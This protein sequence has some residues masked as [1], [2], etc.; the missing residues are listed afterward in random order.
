VTANGEQ[1]W[2]VSRLTHSQIELPKQPSRV[3]QNLQSPFSTTQQFTLLLLPV[4]SMWSHVPQ[5]K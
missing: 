3:H 5:T 1:R 2:R 4:S